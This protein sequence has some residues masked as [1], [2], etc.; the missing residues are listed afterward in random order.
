MELTYFLTFSLVFFKIEI[1]RL[2]VRLEVVLGS[3]EVAVE[4][5]LASQDIV[6]KDFQ[7]KENA[8]IRKTKLQEEENIEVRYCSISFYHSIYSPKKVQNSSPSSTLLFSLYFSSTLSY[9]PIFTCTLPSSAQ[10]GRAS[11]RERVFRR[12]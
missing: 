9:S 3:A 12:V 4:E 2:K 1:E 10:I 7:N 6:R 5:V 11:C 8:L